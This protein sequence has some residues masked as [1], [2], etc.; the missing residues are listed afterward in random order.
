M[1]EQQAVTKGTKRTAEAL[2]PDLDL[3][4][5]KEKGKARDLGNDAGLESLL[6]Q[7]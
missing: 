1:P 5:R 2:E 7:V 6:S 3:D 4:Q